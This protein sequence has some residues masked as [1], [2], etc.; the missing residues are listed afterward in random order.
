MVL[1]RRFLSDSVQISSAK[2][3]PSPPP[4]ASTLDESIAT[5]SQ[6]DGFSR[7]HGVRC[8][9]SSYDKEAK[10]NSPPEWVCGRVELV[11]RHVHAHTTA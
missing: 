11:P 10:K 1:V 3:V 2:V 7:S 6:G 4:S 8:Q 9:Y 5:S